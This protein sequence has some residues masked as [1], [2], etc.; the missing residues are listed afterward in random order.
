MSNINTLPLPL[1]NT[2]ATHAGV[3]HADD[4]F[5]AAFLRILNHQIVVF[6]VQRPDQAPADALL[7]DIGGGQ[8]DHHQPGAEIRPNGVKYAAFGLLWRDFGHLAVPEQYVD[9]FD[10]DFVQP[11]DAADNGAAPTSIYQAIAAFNPNW[12]EDAVFNIRFD[13]AVD[14]AKAILERQFA[15]YQAKAKAESDVQD[16]I[17]YSLDVGYPAIVLGKFM[18]WQ[19][20]VFAHPDNDH[21]NFVIFPAVRGGYQVQAIPTTLNGRDQRK[22]FPAAWLDVK[23]EGA[24]FVHPGRFLVVTDTLD[25]ALHIAKL[26]NGEVE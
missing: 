11:I 18:P 16:A 19:E 1:P 6:R 15:L 14:I 25:A 12:D 23:P 17:A 9:Q 26:A 3:F 20:A 7:F 22:P 8:Y 5:S 10:Q 2:A 24:T 13:Q 21:F 4:V